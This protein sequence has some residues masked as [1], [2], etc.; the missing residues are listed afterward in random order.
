MSFERL[1][2]SSREEWL[3]LRGHGIGGS[4]VSCVV[5]Q[6]PYRTNLQLWQEKTRKVPQTEFED[7]RFTIYGRAV[8]EHLRGITQA[9]FVGLISL[10]HTDELLVRTD[11]PYLRGSLDGEIEVLEDFDFMTYFKKKRVSELEAE[12]EMPKPM[13]LTKGMRGVW[14]AKTTEVLSSMHKE[15]WN[16]V[17][18][19]N[20]YCQVLHYLYVTNYDFVILTAQLTFEDVYKVKTHEIRHYGFMREEKLE[21]LAY[22]EKE[23]DKFW[24]DF[25]LTGIEP[26]LK[27]EF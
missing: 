20:Y 5:S 8:E 19:M 6:N 4:D 16:N 10:T 7:N 1:P 27:L 18:P 23:A 11:K 25:V 21:D 13:H 14:E 3:K 26:P 12:E 15:K 17:I 9:D 22:L 2:Y 24:N